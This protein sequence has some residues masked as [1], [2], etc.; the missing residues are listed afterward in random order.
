M[1]KLTAQRCYEILGLKPGATLAQLREQRGK[2]AQQWHPDK[3]TDPHRKARLEDQ[4]K[5]IN[6]AFDFLKALLSGTPPRPGHHAPP[7]PSPPSTPPP[8]KPWEAEAEARRRRTAE[9]EAVER[10]ERAARQRAWKAEFERLQA[11]AAR[12]LAQKQA[13]VARLQAWLA[14]EKERQDQEA[15]SRDQRT[16]APQG[17]RERDSEHV[18]PVQSAG[19]V[20]FRPRDPR[21]PARAEAGTSKHIYLRGQCTKCGRSKEQIARYALA[22]L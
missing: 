3:E 17:R 4:M 2:L 20:L 7:A 16:R 21:P 9:R 11:D 6:N 15:P 5:D 8:P 14:Q 19:D 22:C 13:D 12:Q 10:R 18:P 1:E